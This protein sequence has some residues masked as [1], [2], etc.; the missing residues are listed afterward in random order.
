MLAPLCPF[1]QLILNLS[2]GMVKNLVLAKDNKNLSPLLPAPNK[3]FFS[4]SFGGRVVSSSL[5]LPSKVT[6]VP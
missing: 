2:T 6:A 1:F 3:L 4:K 5:L